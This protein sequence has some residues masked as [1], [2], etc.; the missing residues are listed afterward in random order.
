MS[1]LLMVIICEKA[2][3]LCDYNS[4]ILTLSLRNGSDM[5]II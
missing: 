3:V 1:G 5:V 4:C 2:F